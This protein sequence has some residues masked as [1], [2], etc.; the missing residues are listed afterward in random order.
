[1]ISLFYWIDP[2]LSGERTAV[3]LKYSGQCTFNMSLNGH[4]KDQ[5]FEHSGV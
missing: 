1:M 2:T 3:K 5:G 4:W